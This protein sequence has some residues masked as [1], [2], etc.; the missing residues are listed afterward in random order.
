MSMVASHLVWLL[1]TKEMRKHAKDSGHT[2][3]EDEDCIQWQEKGIDLEDMFLRV[4]A[5]KDRSRDSASSG[6]PL[7]APQHLV[8]KTVPNA[9]I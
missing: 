3:D 2:F 1:R 6:G 4:F 8:P 9:I 5:K 7:V